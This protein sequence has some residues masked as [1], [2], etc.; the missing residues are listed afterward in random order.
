MNRLAFG[1]AI[2]LV[3]SSLFA[4][5][6]LPKPYF[7]NTAP[8]SWARYSMQYGEFA[9][10]Y[11]YRR[12]DDQDGN[13]R[14]RYEIETLTG[15]TA[16]NKSSTTYVLKPDFPI[17]VRGTD[18]AD[19]LVDLSME[20]NGQ[21]VPTNASTMEAIKTGM[22]RHDSYEPAG[23]DVLNGRTCDKFEYVTVSGGPNP[24]TTV[25]TVWMDASIPFGTVKQVGRVTQDANG[26]VLSEYTLVLLDHGGGQPIDSPTPSSSEGADPAGETS[27]SETEADEPDQPSGAHATARIGD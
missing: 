14:I 1:V 15:E 13:L 11:V 9:L 2:G 6:S 26:E 5:D 12:L 10:E 7:E 25:G 22:S 21:P 20:A 18:F 16:G 4:A 17:G 24:T 3:A 19:W 8:G 27:G 23:Q